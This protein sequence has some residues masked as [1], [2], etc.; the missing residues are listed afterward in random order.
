MDILSVVF[1]QNIESI[2][3]LFAVGHKPETQSKNIPR[4]HQH[5]HYQT[6]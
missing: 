5:W 4:S 1:V 6:V 2:H 3:L